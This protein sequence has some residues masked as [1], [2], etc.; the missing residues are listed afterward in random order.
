MG[1]H[2]VYDKN[3]H[4]L[5]FMHVGMFDRDILA[6]GYVTVPE[7]PRPMPL[8]APGGPEDISEMTVRNYS[9]RVER[10]RAGTRYAAD[11]PFLFLDNPADVHRLP[12]AFTAAQA[13]YLRER[14]GYLRE[15]D[16]SYTIRTTP[17]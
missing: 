4:P 17:K 16:P 10:F 7:R 15:F 13:A 8:F 14:H 11:K 3:L 5:T 6:S 9:L 12:V 2:V 1:F